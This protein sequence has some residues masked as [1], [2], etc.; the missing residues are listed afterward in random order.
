LFSTTASANFYE[1]LAILPRASA[2]LFW[3]ETTGSNRR[4]LNCFKTPRE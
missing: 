4:G 3:I 2:A 1:W